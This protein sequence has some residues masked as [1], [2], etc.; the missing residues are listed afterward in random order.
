MSDKKAKIIYTDTDEA[1]AL[2]TYSLLPIIKSF[3]AGSGIEVETRDISLSGRIIANFSEFLSDSQKQS[4][5]LAELG[6]LT[7]D[8]IC[9]LYT[10]PSPRD[11]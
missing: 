3:T 7:Q 6:E 9:L 2:A 11:S 8:E 4:D 1:P 10:S 5:A